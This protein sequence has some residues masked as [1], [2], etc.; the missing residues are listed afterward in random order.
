MHFGRQYENET[1]FYEIC[2]KTAERRPEALRVYVCRELKQQDRDDPNFISNI[3]TGDE[4]WVYGY[5]PDTKQQ[6]SQ[7][8]SPNSPRPKKARQVRSNDKSMLIFF[9]H[10]RRYPQGIRTN[11]SNRQWQVLLLVFEVAEGEHSAHTSRQV[12]EKQLVSPPS[13]R[14]R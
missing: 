12:E 14:A 13:K 10:P 11:W 2:A 9:R 3:T 6:S 4:T 1:H 5:D 8:K 7:W